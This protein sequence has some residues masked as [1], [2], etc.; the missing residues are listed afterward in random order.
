[1][2]RIGRNQ[3]AAIAPMVPL[4]RQD[5]VVQAGLRGNVAPR[6]HE[7]LDRTLGAHAKCEL[8]AHECGQREQRGSNRDPL[9][10][11]SQHDSSSRPHV[12]WPRG[13]VSGTRTTDGTSRRLL[14]A[15]QTPHKW[16]WAFVQKFHKNAE[17]DADVRFQTTMKSAASH[18]LK[19]QRASGNAGLDGNSGA[20]DQ[21]V[22]AESWPGAGTGDAGS[23]SVKMDPP[24]GRGAKRTDPP[25]ASARPRAIARPSPW[26]RTSGGTP[27]GR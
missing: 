19:A 13:A 24:P 21:A 14:D 9:P 10:L 27:G 11:N 15:A 17:P 8:H 23:S 25:W 3:R 18:R 5:H 22:A 12:R 6:E 16:A 20:A 26:P 7:R 1:M 2:R 4:S